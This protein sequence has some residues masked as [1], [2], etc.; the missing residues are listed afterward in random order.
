MQKRAVSSARNGGFRLKKHRFLKPIYI[1]VY[2]K[3]IYHTDYQ[4]LSRNTK[5]KRFSSTKDNVLTNIGCMCG[6][7]SLFVDFIHNIGVG[8]IVF[9]NG[10]MW[11]VNDVAWAE[12]ALF[13][14]FRNI[15]ETGNPAGVGAWF[16]TFR[17]S[18]EF[19]ARAL[20]R[21]FVFT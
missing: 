19:M 2:I 18:A 9:G 10:V 5:N 16:I 21:L 14:T 8:I 4:H 6:Q 11:T 15:R 13:I 1:F 3:T 7:N 20:E 17:L 12:G